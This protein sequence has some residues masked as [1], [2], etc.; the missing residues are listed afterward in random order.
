MYSLSFVLE[1][2]GFLVPGGA[3]HTTTGGNGHVIWYVSGHF[4]TAFSIVIITS[5]MFPAH[6]L[7]PSAELKQLLTA[8]EHP[9]ST[10]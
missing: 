7:L 9:E 6:K 1:T 5:V 4:A 10:K 3:L 8:P 2:P